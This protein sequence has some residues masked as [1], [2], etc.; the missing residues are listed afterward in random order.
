MNAGSASHVSLTER[1]GSITCLRRG[2]A[3]PLINVYDCFYVFL[4]WQHRVTRRANA[5]PANAAH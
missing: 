4:R 2:T 1:K 5:L 3:L